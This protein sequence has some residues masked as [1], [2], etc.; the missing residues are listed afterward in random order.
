M[1]STTLRDLHDIKAPCCLRLLLSNDASSLDLLFHQ[2][3]ALLVWLTAASSESL[4]TILIGANVYGGAV[5]GTVASWQEGSWFESCL[6]ICMEFCISA[7]LWLPPTKTWRLI[8][9]SKL[10]IGV[11]T[12][13][14]V[15]MGLAPA[16]PQPG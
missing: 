5:V 2:M 12:G 15:Q 13:D 3:S 14:C 4:A 11:R 1:V 16:P 7:I 6:Y 9:D 10:P 8:A